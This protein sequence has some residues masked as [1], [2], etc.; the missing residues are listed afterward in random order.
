MRVAFSPE[1]MSNGTVVVRAEN[2]TKYYGSF[3]AVDHVSFSIRKGEVVGLLGPNG[4]GKSTMIHML[5]GLL[6]PSEGDIAIFGLPLAQRRTDILQR[7]N[8]AASYAT[9]PYNLTVSEALMTFAG[10]YGVK[11]RKKKVREL[12]ERFGIAQLH[13][14]KIGK[15]S[16]GETARL[17][18]AKAL[19]NDPELLFFDEPTTSLDP[20]FADHIRTAI[21]ELQRE[22]DLTILWTSHNMREVEIM[23]QR[24]LFL[25]Q[26]KIIA[27]GSP[28]E[29]MRKIRAEDLEDVFISFSRDTKQ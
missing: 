16:S 14:K 9:L 18:L 29:L 22:R 1:G 11:E 6:T 24:V 20:D 17:S 7:V 2:L 19:L 8:C 12:V 5:L 26:G 28:E 25:K 27:D 10:I 13:D 3:C 4:A 23:C 21:R 15:L